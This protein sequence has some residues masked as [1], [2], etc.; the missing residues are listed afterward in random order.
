MK[1]L[2]I[3]IFINQKNETENFQNVHNQFQNLLYHCLNNV[4]TI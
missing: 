1:V 4:V 2:K 3:N